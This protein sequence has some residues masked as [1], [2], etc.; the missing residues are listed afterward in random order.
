MKIKN[1]KSIL[2][3]TIV[4]STLSFTAGSAHAG[5]IVLTGHDI[6]SHG[7]QNGYNLVILD[8]LRG[9]GT[10]SEIARA[11]YNVGTLRGGFNAVSGGVFASHSAQNV[12][13]FGSVAAFTAFLGTVDAI[14]LP[15]FT[16]VAT[17]AAISGQ[18]QTITRQIITIGCRRALPQPEPASAAAAGSPRRR[19]ALPSASPTRWS[20][21]FHPQHFHVIR[22]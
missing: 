12:S 20:M 3:T 4:A 8:Y 14:V 21:A 5:S 19:K 7:N 10:G 15:E 6:L 16:T 9:A 17:L 22:Q 18:I 1:L 13:S 2:A 11:S